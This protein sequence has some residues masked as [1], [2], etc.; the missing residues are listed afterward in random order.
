M[1]LLL[2]AG[3]SG[4]EVDKLAAALTRELGGDA[5]SFPV[6]AQAGAAINEEFLAAV[7]LWQSGVG[8]I[9]DGIVGPRCQVLL[10]M[11]PP[12]GDKFASLA[13]TVG[14]VSRLFPA[15]K[16]ANIARYLPYIEAALGVAGLTDRPMV[17]G[18][19]GTIRAETE[20]FVPISNSSRSTTRRRE[21]HLSACTT[22]SWATTVR[23]K[24]PAIAV[25]ASSS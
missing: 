18:A 14:N 2:D 11:I 10:G 25:A 1:Q 20:G 21:A 13:V 4:A 16:P 6:L 15:T 23:A 5:A 7:R 17:V 3:D 8:I 22:T 19:L 9:A 12:Q 24:G